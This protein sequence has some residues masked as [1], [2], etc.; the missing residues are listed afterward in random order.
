METG[1]EDDDIC[2]VMIPLSRVH[3]KSTFLRVSGLDESR[4][5]LECKE[6]AETLLLFMHCH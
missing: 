6:A 1:K 3:S 2:V 4:R 5:F